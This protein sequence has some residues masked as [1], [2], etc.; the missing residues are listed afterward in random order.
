M[1]Y[2]INIWE[3]I[4]E[5]KKADSEIFRKEMLK[6]TKEVIEIVLFDFKVDEVYITGSILIAEKFSSR[7]DIDIAVRGLPGKDYFRFMARLQELLPQVP[8][9]I[10]LENCRFAD[11]IE[12]TG[13]RI[14]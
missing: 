7:S 9:V 5:R 14:K 1:T 4:E 2:P 10:E 12:K 3:Q 6:K 8:E 11:N 13:M